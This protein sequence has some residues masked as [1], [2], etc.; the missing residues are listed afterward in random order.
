MI[1]GLVVLSNNS[2]SKGN[3]NKQSPDKS[4][5]GFLSGN[6][7]SRELSSLSWR[8]VIPNLYL[9]KWSAHDNSYQ[10]LKYYIA[11]DP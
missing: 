10:P 6:G 5:Q 4:E 1:I 7:G 9:D 3:Y 2:S 11:V 8:W